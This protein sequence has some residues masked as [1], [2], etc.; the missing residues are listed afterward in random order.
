[1]RARFVKLVLVQLS[2]R[3]SAGTHNWELVRRVLAPGRLDLRRRDVVVLPELLD[4]RP[5]RK[6]YEDA[7]RGL[8]CALGC[9]VVGGS[10]YERRGSAKINSGI[11]ADAA[12]RIVSRYE[13][14]RPYGRPSAEVAPG[15]TQ[16]ELRIDGRRVLVAVCADFW[17]S[18][19]FQRLRALPELVLVPACSVTRKPSPRFARALW[20][21][22]AVARAYEFGAYVG[23]SDWA[24][25]SVIPRAP[26]AVAGFA[27]PTRT[28]PRGF[29]TPVGRRGLGFFELD[30]DALDAFRAD[31]LERGFWAPVRPKSI[32]APLGG[33]RCPSSSAT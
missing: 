15:E 2:L 28:E 10:H 29:F 30:F 14:L 21:H 23:I 18:E 8:A 31:R 22:M 16:G 25:D 24:L 13:K 4:V 9:H 12:G 20:R 6:A 11:V 26:G 17:F 33:T 7:V 5:E 27:D 32:S 3:S 19:V 1:M